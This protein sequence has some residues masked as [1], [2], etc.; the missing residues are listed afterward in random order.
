[1]REGLWQRIE[2]IFDAFGWN[3]VRLKYGALQQVAFE[4][5]R[6]QVLK[7]WIYA[8]PNPLYSALTF[9][10]GAAWRKRLMEEI[11]DQVEVSALLDRRSDAELAM[12]MENLGGHCLE[13]LTEAFA[14]IDHDRPTA[15]LA[16][17]IKGWG[18]PLAGHKDNHAGLMTKAQMQAFQQ[19]MGV[20]AGAE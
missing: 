14:A 13:T 15:F 5:P 7:G 19:Q 17:T 11:G 9:Q 8:C 20:A 3:V 6:G 1:M 4:E 16:Y 10:G 12:L 18:T 2:A